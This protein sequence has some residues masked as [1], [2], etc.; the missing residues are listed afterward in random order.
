MLQYILIALIT[1]L[2]VWYIKFRWN[3][4]NLYRLADK[5]HGPKGLPLFG[6]AFKILGK[7]PQGKKQ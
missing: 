2:A 5:I 7:N 3:R 6:V 4:R 1:A